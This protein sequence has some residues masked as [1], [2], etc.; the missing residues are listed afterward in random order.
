MSTKINVI[1][2]GQSK[3]DT[4]SVLKNVTLMSNIAFQDQVIQEDTIYTIKWNYNLNGATVNIPARCVLDFT[5]GKL[6][7]GTINWNG[8]KILNRYQYS[9]LENITETGDKIIL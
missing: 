2:R 5:G 9:I 3:Q 4:D 7:N 1:I 8:T 6:S